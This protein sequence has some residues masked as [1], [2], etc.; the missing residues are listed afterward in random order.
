LNG[1]DQK[2]TMVLHQSSSQVYGSAKSEESNPWNAV[3]SGSIDGSQLELTVTSLKGTSMATMKLMGT[4]VK[5]SLSGIYLQSDDLGGY[6]SNLFTATLINPDTSSYSPAEIETA[7]PSPQAGAPS[8]TE[9]T[10]QA[11]SSSPDSPGITSSIAPVPVSDT[12][13]PV[14]LGNTYK[15]VHSIASTVPESL[16]VGFIGDG[17]MGAGGASMS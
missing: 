11:E 10:S 4:I 14:Q 5:G 8:Q 16:G 9:A 15:D 1:G 17:T 7:K 6:S 2:V 13:K 12:S 3:V